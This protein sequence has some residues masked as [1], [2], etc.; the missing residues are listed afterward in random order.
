MKKFCFTLLFICAASI[1]SFAPV[2]LYY[3][4]KDKVEHKLKVKID[5]NYQEITFPAGKTGRIKIK[6]KE[7]QCLVVTSCGEVNIK[8]DDKFEI[9]NGCIKK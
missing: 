7:T 9:I 4:N 5:G 1:S 3:T 2:N 8:D 6:G